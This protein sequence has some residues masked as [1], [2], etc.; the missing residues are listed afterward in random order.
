MSFDS[1]S[2]F[3]VD[4]HAH[5]LNS[6][7]LDLL[8]IEIVPMAERLVHELEIAGGRP[9]SSSGQQSQQHQNGAGTGKDGVVKEGGAAA[10][11]VV[12][13]DEEEVREAMF[14]RLESLG[15]RVGQ[16]LAERYV[17]SHVAYAVCRV[18]VSTGLLEG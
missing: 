2:L 15:F 7:C 1:P 5:F 14:Y 16:G 11:T 3:P 9:A 10:S 18:Y 6:S 17:I 13:A 4:P 12:K 8:L